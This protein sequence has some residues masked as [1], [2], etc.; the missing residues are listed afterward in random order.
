MQPGS[1][2][3]ISNLMFCDVF[4]LLAADVLLCSS[5]CQHG[6]PWIQIF[7]CFFWLVSLLSWCF[8]ILGG[9]QLCKHYTRNHTVTF[10][11]NKMKQWIMKNKTKNKSFQVSSALKSRIIYTPRLWSVVCYQGQWSRLQIPKFATR[12][13]LEYFASSIVLQRHCTGCTVH[14]HKPLNLHVL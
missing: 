12:V 9:C 1:P 7:Y 4:S 14:S 6:Q 5:H 13:C 11:K 10:S 3:W 2:S 8:Q